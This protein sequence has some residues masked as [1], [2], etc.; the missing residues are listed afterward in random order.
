[1]IFHNYELAGGLL[2][3]KL[4]YVEVILNIF[5]FS[6]VKEFVETLLAYVNKFS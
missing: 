3:K 1:M 5:E 6:P 4:K 2:L